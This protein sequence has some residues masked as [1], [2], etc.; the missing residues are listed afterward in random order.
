METETLLTTPPARATRP[1]ADGH[2]TDDW[3]A[4]VTRVLSG[5]RRPDD[6]LP[7]PDEVRRVVDIDMAY[8]QQ[9]LGA[10]P[11]NSTYI[12]QL[13]WCLLSFHHGGQNIGIVRDDRGIIVVAVGL[14]QV[15]AICHT[16]PYELTKAVAFDAPDIWI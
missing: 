15:A 16:M 6:Y 9:R 5:D 10:E 1:G 4:W 8:A 2:P 3:R 11:A 7:V 14:D 13:H 12:R